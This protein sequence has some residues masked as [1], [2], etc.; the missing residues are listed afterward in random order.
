ML[1]L[2]ATGSTAIGQGI[3]FWLL[4]IGIIVFGLLGFYFAGTI[5][6]FHSAPLASTKPK[7]PRSGKSTISYMT[8]PKPLTAYMNRASFGVAYYG[9]ASLMRLASG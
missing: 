4:A 1:A 5:F 6:A 8:S 7:L 2:I 9:H 3:T